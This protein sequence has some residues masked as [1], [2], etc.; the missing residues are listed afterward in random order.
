MSDTSTCPVCGFGGLYEP[1]WDNDAASH[2]ICPSCGT[3]FGF[4][5][6]AGGK[7]DERVLAHRTLREKWIEAG[8]PWFSRDRRQ[9]DGWDALEQLRVVEDPVPSAEE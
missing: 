2:E 9:P 4:D 3:H 8:S 1:P 7:A 5:D 6:A